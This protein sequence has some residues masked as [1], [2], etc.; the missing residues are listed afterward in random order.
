MKYIEITTKTPV[1]W[2]TLAHQYLGNCFNTLP[3][4]QA[5]PN[6][7]IGAFIPAGVNIKIPVDIDT[8]TVDTSD[9]P[10]WKQENDD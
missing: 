3:L 7:P 8:T 6:V 5:N 1:R 10:I 2:D 4:I 9:L